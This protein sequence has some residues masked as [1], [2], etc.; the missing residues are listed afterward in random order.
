MQR[1]GDE[2]VTVCTIIAKNYLSYARVLTDSF[3]E[4][5]PNGNVF[6]LL[7]DKVDGYFN[8]ETERFRLVTVD[9]L[10]SEEVSQM[11]FRYSTI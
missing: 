11:L 6:V 4:H 2:T 10:G 7:V 1:Q 8:P 3:L 9:E 5:H